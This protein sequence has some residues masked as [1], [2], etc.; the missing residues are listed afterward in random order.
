MPIFIKI[1]LSKCAKKKKNFV[2]S[3]VNKKKKFSFNECVT[4]AVYIYYY[5]IATERKSKKVFWSFAFHFHNEK[6]KCEK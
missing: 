3:L 2:R 4:H 5:I 6:K 1:N